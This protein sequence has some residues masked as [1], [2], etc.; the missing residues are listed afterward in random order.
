MRTAK[1]S[2][3]KTN[4]NRL[5]FNGDCSFLFTGIY[6]ENS[7]ERFTRDTLHHFID[8]LASSGVDTYI[9]NPNAQK[10][11]YPSRA[12]PPV[13]EGYTRGDREFFRGNYPSTNDTFFTK[14]KL[15]NC[16]TE[17]VKFLNRYVDLLEDNVDWLKEISQACR[18]N[19]ISPWV[20]VRM[21]DAHGAVNWEKSY[22][23]CDLQK[24][25]RYRLSGRVLGLCDAVSPSQ[26]LLNYEHREVRN[27]YFAMMRELVEEYDYEGLELDWLRGP[28]CCEP[29]AAKST[30]DMMTDWISQIRELTN[31]KA[32]KNGRPYMLGLRI[33]VRLD[34]MKTI[35]LDIAALAQNG[36]IDY[37]APSNFWQTTWDVPYEELQAEVG[38]TVSIYGVIEN[39]PNW[40]SCD[41]APEFSSADFHIN[42]SS[43]RCLSAS[44]ELLRGNSAG[45]LAQGADGIYMY[46]F[47][48]TDEPLHNPN[49]E[50]KQA[51]YASL[52]DLHN[53]NA[54]RS[55]PKHYT[56]STGNDSRMHP[57]FEF[58]DQLP[59]TLEVGEQRAFTISMCA[60]TVM[61]DTTLELCV[62]IV[63][64]GNQHTSQIS[65][66]FNGCLPNC[67]AKITNELVF[68]TGVFTHHRKENQALNFYFSAQ[69]IKEG[70]NEVRIFNTNVGDVKTALVHI[71][72]LELAVK[73]K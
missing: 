40:L 13:W 28:S 5:L 67:D 4:N 62:Q 51:K 73:Y 64:K 1:G 42:P 14:E 8:L 45:K 54:L 46:N 50:I 36:L 48:C 39:A 56:L 65:V 15:N 34:T 16:L 66:S 52:S 27:Y 12:L 17:N 20:S 3:V 44:A 38:D 37:I 49:P 33:P 19:Q 7:E 43:H 25:A 55:K 57:F 31:R 11:W 21:N 30:L 53:L 59:V 61:P 72:S 58:A 23:N 18:R 63:L 32:E 2:I 35:G 26:Q 69:Q 68:P 60:E 6:Q 70:W 71:I 41:V 47:F 24:D 10:P 22:M 9:Q 29:P